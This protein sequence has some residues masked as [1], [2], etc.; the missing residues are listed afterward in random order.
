MT[1]TFHHR[2]T[3]GAKCGLLLLGGLVIYLFWVKHIIAATLV[4]AFLVLMMERVLHS[5]YVF[6]DGFLLIRRGRFARPKTIPL[7]EI[8]SCRPITTTFGTV[9][10]L[11]IGYGRNRYAAVQPAQETAF[12]TH[13]QELIREADNGDEP[14]K[15]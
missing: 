4:A 14:A 3:L 7:M 8:T 9:H 11:L 12:V 6:R 10:Y 13:L 2:F 1:R 5:E 15:E